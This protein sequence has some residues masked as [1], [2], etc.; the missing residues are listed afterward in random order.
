MRTTLINDVNTAKKLALDALSSIGIKDNITVKVKEFK[1]DNVNSVG[2][3]RSFTQFGRCPIFWINSQFHS[4]FDNKRAAIVKIE[5][6]RTIIHE[7]GHVIAEWFRIRGED[8]YKYIM[9]NFID[10]EDFAEEFIYYVDEKHDSKFE[11]IIKR[12]VA[13][14]FE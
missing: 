2:L 14:V 7:Y 11:P 10:E 9:D 12:Y 8:M 4:F 6:H 1:R 5:L 13:E 3:Y